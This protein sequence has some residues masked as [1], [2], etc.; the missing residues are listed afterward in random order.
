LEKTGRR[1]RC[2]PPVRAEVQAA[3]SLQRHDRPAAQPQ[4]QSSW[5]GAA[6][7]PQLQAG[8]AQSEQRQAKAVVA[9]VS[10]VFMIV[11]SWG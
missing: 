9:N 8:P 3:A 10:V 11:S 6:W 2:T 7:Q 4:L 1:A 5:A